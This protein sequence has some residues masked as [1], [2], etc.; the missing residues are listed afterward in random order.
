MPEVDLVE[1]LK[2]SLSSLLCI[3]EIT[4]MAFKFISVI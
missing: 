3:D 2:K 4:T 1:L